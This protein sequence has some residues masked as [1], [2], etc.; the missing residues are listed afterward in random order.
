MC[1]LGGGEVGFIPKG[2]FEEDNRKEWTLTTAG[3]SSHDAAGCQQGGLI[4]SDIDT[5]AGRLV[6]RDG[7]VERLDIFTERSLRDENV[8]RL[9]QILHVHHIAVRCQHDLC[10]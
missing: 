4:G 8:D 1:D 5:D 10:D 2:E 7:D 6:D 3:Q 9:R